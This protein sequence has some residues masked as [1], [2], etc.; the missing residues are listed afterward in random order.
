MKNRITKM[1]VAVLLASAV[2][3]NAEV[4]N[5]ARLERDLSAGEYLRQREGAVPNRILRLAVG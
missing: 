5:Q 1:A 4:W 3:G 2:V